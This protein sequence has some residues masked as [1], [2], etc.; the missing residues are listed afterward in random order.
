MHQPDSI[1][2][3]PA[4][5]LTLLVLWEATMILALGRLGSETGVKIMPMEGPSWSQA[6]TDKLLIL[7]TSTSRPRQQ[8]QLCIYKLLED[9]DQILYLSCVAGS[10]PQHMLDSVSA[11]WEQVNLTES[12]V[13][14][15]THLLFA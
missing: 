4:Y 14:G 8:F 12:K 13:L 5:Q 15:I 10:E 1:P 7:E 3:A 11:G 6:E 9:M 2:N